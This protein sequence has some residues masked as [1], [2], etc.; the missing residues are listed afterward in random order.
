VKFCPRTRLILRLFGCLSIDY[1][2]D[3]AIT[4]GRFKRELGP[5]ATG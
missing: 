2:H 3:K 4:S 5:F 1:N